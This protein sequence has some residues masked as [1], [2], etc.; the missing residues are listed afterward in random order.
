MVADDPTVSRIHAEASLLK[1]GKAEVRDCESKNGLFVLRDGVRERVS[2]AVIGKGDAVILGAHEMSG[3]RIIECLSATTVFEKRSSVPEPP[4]AEAVEAA[5][6]RA[7]RPRKA[8][9]KARKVTRDPE[10]NEL[11][12]ED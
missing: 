1:S 2:K 11:R 5:S 12:Y 7:A 9:S 6:P 8:L 3:A 4:V 10:T